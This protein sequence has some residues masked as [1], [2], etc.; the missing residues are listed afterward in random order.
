MQPAA[1][2][3]EPRG[4]WKKGCVDM[5]SALSHNSSCP[6]TSGEYKEMSDVTRT[7]VDSY[8]HLGFFIYLLIL[9]SRSVNHTPNTKVPFHMLTCTPACPSAIA[10]GTSNIHVPIP[11]YKRMREEAKLKLYSFPHINTVKHGGLIIKY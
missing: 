8:Q 11:G 9:S 4:L 10:A 1:R 2:C 3:Q 7:V 6:H 5:E